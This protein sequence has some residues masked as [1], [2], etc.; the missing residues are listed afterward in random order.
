MPFHTDA[1]QA[2]L[3][4]RLANDKMQETNCR[5]GAV[6]DFVRMIIGVIGERSYI[7][8][9]EIA[10]VY[11]EYCR[12]HPLVTESAKKENASCA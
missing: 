1:A 8:R 10:D 4:M 9:E 7:G 11:E 2:V 5:R 12:N 3:E 6:N